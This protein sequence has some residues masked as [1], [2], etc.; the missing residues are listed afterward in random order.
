MRPECDVRLSSAFAVLAAVAVPAWT[1][2]PAVAEP[3]PATPAGSGITTTVKLPAEVK[4]RPKGLTNEMMI[5]KMIAAAPEKPIAPPQRP[6]KL[7]VF[8]LC[9]GYV[10]PAIPHVAAVIEIMGKKTGA[11]ETVITDDPSC[12]EA[13][14]LNAFDAVVMDNTVNQSVFLT[15]EEQKRLKEKD[16]AVLEKW[17]RLKKNF[18]EFVKGGKGV[19]GFHGGADCGGMW[20]EYQEM[21]GGHFGGHPWNAKVVCR[22]ESPDNAINAAA[23]PGESFVEF[24]D[25]IYIFRGPCS[26]ETHRVLLSLDLEKCAALHKNESKWA[27]ERGREDGDNPMIWI[28][29]HGGGRV[30]YSAFGGH[31]FELCWTPAMLKHWLAGIQYALGDL[32]ADDAPS[33]AASAPKLPSDIQLDRIAQL[34]PDQSPVKPVKTRKLLVLAPGE[35]RAVSRFLAAAVAAIGKKSGAYEAVVI[36]NLEILDADKLQPFDAV[37][38]LTP[39]GSFSPSG[40]ERRAGDKAAIAA[41]EKRRKTLIEFVRGGKGLVGLQPAAAGAAKSWPELAEALGGSYDWHPWQKAVVRVEVPD[42]PVNAVFQGKQGFAVEE[43]IPMV[44]DPYSREKARILLGV[45]AEK[46]GL[47]DPKAGP[48]RGR[49]DG[50]NALSWIKPCGQGRVYYSAFGGASATV[51]VGEVLRHWL[52]GIQYAIGDLP[53]DASPSGKASAPPVHPPAPPAPPKGGGK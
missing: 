10:H 40:A 28:K 22:V 12:F 15:E 3:S 41:Y 42:H 27:P 38:L 51:F 8:T 24:T 30:Y 53:A 7:L 50:D 14:K 36:D 4:G 43:P 49:E 20:P 13:D 5:Q 33:G 16:K 9:T 47:W 31:E 11:Y 48:R 18:S 46:S 26:R 23:I 21:I 17:E 37:C 6:R 34:A 1:G 29:R 44:H 52:A 2:G 45:D 19:V 25:E 32:K 35:R 39:A